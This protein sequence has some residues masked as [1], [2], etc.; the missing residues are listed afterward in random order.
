MTLKENIKRFKWLIIGLVAI[1]IFM[2]AWDHFI[3][4]PNA[5]KKYLTFY[6]TDMKGTLT[7]LDGSAGVT[8]FKIEGNDSMFF[9]TP[10]CIDYH[11]CFELIATKGDLITKPSKTDTLILSH[12]GNLYRFTFKKLVTDDQITE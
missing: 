6:K 1:I 12:Q 5:Q 4:F 10:K 8:H 7:Y 11:V 2:N 3:G 9:F